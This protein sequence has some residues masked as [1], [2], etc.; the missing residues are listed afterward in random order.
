LQPRAFLRKYGLEVKVIPQSYTVNLFLEVE[1]GFVLGPME[2][3]SFKSKKI[4]LAHGD[5]LFLYTDGI[6]EAMNPQK[7]F[8]TEARLKRALSGL[9]GRDITDMVHE[10]RKEISAFVQEEPQSDDITMLVLRFNKN[11]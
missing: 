10:L 8:F 2:N 9:K 5:C 7:E 3:F 11:T 4:K 1:K 6:T